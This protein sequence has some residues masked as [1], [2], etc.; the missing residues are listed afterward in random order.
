[1]VITDA[2]ADGGIVTINGSG[3][4]GYAVGSITS[5]T[6][7]FTTGNGTR[8]TT[9]RVEGTIE[10]WSNT[11]IVAQFDSAPNEVTVTSVFGTVT[12]EVDSGGSSWA[13]SIPLVDATKMQ[14]SLSPYGG[15]LLVEEQISGQRI[16]GIGAERDGVIFW[17]DTRGTVFF[18]IV[19][20]DAATMQGIVINF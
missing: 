13:L 19:D 17:F 5:V 15:L 9:R 18:G 6:A 7:T 1:V 14:V 16:Y 12:S 20:H 10:S 4:G 8:I 2:T 3:F 11:T